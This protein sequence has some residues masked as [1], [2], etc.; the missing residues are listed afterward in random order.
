MFQSRVA[1]KISAGC[2]SQ[3]WQG[4]YLQGVSDK[5]GKVDICRV[6]QSRVARYRYLQGVS[7]KGGK[8]DIWA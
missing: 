1:R 4:R 6:F 3:G 7:D 5:G 2:F 8:V